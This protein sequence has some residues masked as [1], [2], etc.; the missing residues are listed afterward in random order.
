[1]RLHKRSREVSPAS[2]IESHHRLSNDKEDS[3]PRQRLDRLRRELLKKPD[4]AAVAAARPIQ[5]AFP[6]PESQARFG[7]RR[8]IT[9]SDRTRL[10]TS[11]SRS[12]HV[13]RHR[14]RKGSP[15]EAVD[16]SQM[17][18]R[19]NGK[20]VVKR[21]TDSVPDQP[22]NVSS[23]S[24]L[25][26]SDRPVSTNQCMRAHSPQSFD[27]SDVY[28][29]SSLL[30]GSCKPSEIVHPT[31]SVLDYE[32]YV[33]NPASVISNSELKRCLGPLESS[34]S[35][36]PYSSEAIS[37][38]LQPQRAPRVISKSVLE[39]DLLEQ[40]DLQRHSSRSTSPDRELLVRRRFTIDDQIDAERKGMLKLP[41]THRG[42]SMPQDQ[43]NKDR[44][45]TRARSPLSI[46]SDG[47]RLDHLSA[48]TP[49]LHEYA[50]LPGPRLRLE[51]ERHKTDTTSLRSRARPTT[52]YRNAR[53]DSSL[54][55]YGQPVPLEWE[56]HRRPTQAPAWGSIDMAKGLS[57]YNSPSV[58]T[59]QRSST[60]EAALS[61]GQFRFTNPRLEPK[62]TV[63]YRQSTLPWRATGP[64]TRH[65]QPVH[66][67]GFVL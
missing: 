23:Q 50:W 37:P 61:P 45:N 47:R 11:G 34:Q 52:S 19:I 18:L 9:E 8:K 27:G 64:T 12:V 55:V 59:P 6:T 48:T 65:R 22:V 51:K 28:Q 53:Q 49:P 33:P 3:Q 30:L 25:L 35:L 60:S 5:I 14:K 21:N 40:K 15:M 16:F 36:R 38:S 63:D 56:S 62:S 7:K 2:V 29:D 10:G 13:V 31:S 41:W 42:G 20:R 66:T 54:K 46:E 67:S 4:W 44:L 17:S 24:M 26:D 57:S 58:S 1:M 43:Y 39:Q 32:S